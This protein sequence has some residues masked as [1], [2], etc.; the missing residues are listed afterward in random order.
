MKLGQA[1]EMTEVAVALAIA[2]QVRLGCQVASLWHWCTKGYHPKGNRR[3]SYALLREAEDGLVSA[4]RRAGIEPAVHN[5][6]GSTEMR[7]W[8]PRLMFGVHGTVQPLA[9]RNKDARRAIRCLAAACTVEPLETAYAVR[10]IGTC[11]SRGSSHRR[12][13]GVGNHGCT[14]MDTDAVDAPA[15]YAPPCQNICVHPCASVVSTIFLSG[16]M[17]AD[18]RVHSFRAHLAHEPGG[19]PDLGGATNLGAVRTCQR[20]GGGDGARTG[21]PQ[22]AQGTGLAG[23]A[24][25]RAGRRVALRRLHRRHDGRGGGQRLRTGRHRALRPQA[26]RRRRGSAGPVDHRRGPVAQ[27]KRHRP[28][29]EAPRIFPAAFAAPLPDRLGRQT[30]DRSSPAGR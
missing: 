25:R 7:G 8:R 15:A 30:A 9:T 26:A 14:R 10:C 6:F 23:A 29:L 28:G 11:Q 1:K 2:S 27:H 3:C 17:N 19:I 13:E 22:P 20:C 24:S 5:Q 21:G 16:G 12:H 18:D 4:G